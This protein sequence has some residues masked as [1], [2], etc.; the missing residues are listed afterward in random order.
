[1]SAPER[2]VSQILYFRPS[3]CRPAQC[4]LG[5]MLPFAPFPP[6][7]FS[8]KCHKD[9]SSTEHISS[10]GVPQGSVLGPILFIIYTSTTPQHSISHQSSLSLNCHLYADDTQL[11]SVHSRNFHSSIAHFQTALQH[12]SSR[13]RP[14][15][16]CFKNPFLHNHSGSV[17][18]HSVTN[19]GR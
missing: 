5:R 18:L 11:F 17:V 8:V 13:L 15:L 6:P 16:I 9:F 7:L 4:R 2:P 1:M 14:K 10:C 19:L 12:L 3:K